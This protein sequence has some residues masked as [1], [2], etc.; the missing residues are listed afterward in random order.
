MHSY[1]ES[2]G[3]ESQVAFARYLKPAVLQDGLL[4]QFTH[5]YVLKEG[6]LIS[7]YSRVNIQRLVKRHSPLCL[8]RWEF[9]KK[10]K[11]PFITSEVMTYVSEEFLVAF[12]TVRPDGEP[13][14]QCSESSA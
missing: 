13:Q 6:D 1:L 9:K 10:I 3:E 14:L 4:E 8:R 12:N 2:E 5:L 7:I 11:E